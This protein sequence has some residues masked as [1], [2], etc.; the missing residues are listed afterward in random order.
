M[1]EAEK[2]SWRH[3]YLPQFFIKGF[4]TPSNSFWVYDKQ[5]DK[6]IE[7]E[8]FPKSW[9]F[10]EE[11]NNITVNGHKT[12]IIETKAYQF[13]DNALAKQFK[14]IQEAP[15]NETENVICITHIAIM[16]ASTVYR[17]PATEDIAQELLLSDLSRKLPEKIEESVKSILSFPM[18]KEDKL[19]FLTILGPFL[20]VLSSDRTEWQGKI[21]YEIIEAENPCFILSDNPALYEHAP[22]TYHDLISSV[23]FPLTSKR[24]YLGL[25]T[26]YYTLSNA[27]AKDINFLL[28]LQAKRYFASADKNFLEQVVTAYRILKPIQNDYQAF[29]T[30][31][32]NKINSKN[33]LATADTKK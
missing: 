5:T 22:K 26:K 20:Y 24:I 19:K 9:F 29:K 23:I 31:V 16:L 33:E 7:Q 11:R 13:L 25:K 4:F 30:D 17:I 12:D 32:F 3:H 18:S 1:K 15:V 14:I 8:K 27:L 6:I 10:E 21:P 2:I 28:A